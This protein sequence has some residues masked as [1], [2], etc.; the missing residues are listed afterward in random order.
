MAMQSPQYYRDHAARARRLASSVDK[1]DVV[2]TLERLARD[3]EDIAIDLENGA[4]EITHPERL[5]QL[6][7]L[8]T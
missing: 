8:D 3:Y 6:K 4:V 5:P 7:H 2:D 1:S